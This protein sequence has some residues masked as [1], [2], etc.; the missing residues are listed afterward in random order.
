MST[1][2]GVHLYLISV[3]KAVRVLK[4]TV[5]WHQYTHTEISLLI[6]VFSQNCP[7]MFR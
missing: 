3:H 5:N 4:T 7:S 6:G 2:K 1:S